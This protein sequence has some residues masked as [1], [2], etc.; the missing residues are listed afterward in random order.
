VLECSSARV[1]CSG[2]LCSSARVLCSGVLCCALVCC[3][4]VLE[5]CALVCCALV[6]ECCVLVLEC[7]SARVL[8]F[9]RSSACM[10]WQLPCIPF[11]Y[12]TIIHWLSSMMT[13]C[14]GPESPGVVHPAWSPGWRRRR[15]TKKPGSRLLKGIL[16]MALAWFSIALIGAAVIIASLTV[17][18]WLLRVLMS[19]H[20]KHDVYAFGMGF[21]V[22]STAFEMSSHLG[23]RIRTQPASEIV[24]SIGLRATQGAKCAVAVILMGG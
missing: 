9:S 6:L 14:Q 24:Q 7:S 17:G 2:V 20:V 23:Q 18:R 10:S 1:L 19:V 11:C 21:C 5:C 22:C 12:L 13:G 4:L 16:M 8:C 3:A 15:A